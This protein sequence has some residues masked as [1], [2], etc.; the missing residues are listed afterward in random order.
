[1][2][3]AE[4]ARVVAQ[5]ARRGSV[6]AMKIAYEMLQAEPRPH[7]AA[8][9]AAAAADAMMAEVDELAARRSHDQRGSGLG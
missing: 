2:D 3:A 1:M 5:A 8:A 9:A 6:S 4:L 7:T